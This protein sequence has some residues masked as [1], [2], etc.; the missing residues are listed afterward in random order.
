MCKEAFPRDL[1]SS[2]QVPQKG[3][4]NKSPK[5][6]RNPT[7]QEG[8][9]DLKGPLLDPHLGLNMELQSVV[10]HPGKPFKVSSAGAL[11]HVGTKIRLASRE[12]PDGCFCNIAGGK[13]FLV[14]QPCLH[15]KWSQHAP[16]ARITSHNKPCKACC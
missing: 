12:P 14:K 2:E 16:Q 8:L 5:G 11:I 4:E 3:P 15:S 13:S 1:D 10:A 7:H 6:R 9:E